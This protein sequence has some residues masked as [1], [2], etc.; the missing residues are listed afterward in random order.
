MNQA[1]IGLSIAY[2]ALGVLLLGLTV[3]ARLPLW[4]KVLSILLVSALYFVT[5]RSLG[6]MQGWPTAESPPERFLLLASSIHEPDKTT[7]SPGMIYIWAS[8]L[9]ENRPAAEPRAYQIPYSTDLHTQ[10]EEADK[11]IRDGIMQLG[12]SE[13]VTAAE[14][15]ANAARFAQKRK[16]IR[17]YDLPDPE[18]PEK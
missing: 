11:R 14:S 7:G 3:N 9:A 15:P 2:V 17:L 6:G 12:K 8:S 1:V 10:F 13:W 4:V 16:L 5:Y 18:L